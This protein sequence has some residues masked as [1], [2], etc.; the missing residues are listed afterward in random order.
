MPVGGSTVGAIS[1]DFGFFSEILGS[2]CREQALEKAKKSIRPRT[3]L[4]HGRS[5]LLSVISSPYWREKA[6]R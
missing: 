1:K 4:A 6:R 3:I 5:I 2:F